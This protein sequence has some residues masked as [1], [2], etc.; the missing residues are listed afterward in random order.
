M[1]TAR[2]HDWQMVA[3]FF[4][5]PQGRFFIASLRLLSLEGKKKKRKPVSAAHKDIYTFG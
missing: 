3:F 5:T 1:T 4:L 2:G